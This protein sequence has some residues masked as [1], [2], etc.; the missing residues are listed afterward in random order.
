MWDRSTT[1]AV[2]LAAF[3]LAQQAGT[4]AVA[5]TQTTAAPIF[6]TQAACIPASEGKGYVLYW[7]F[8]ALSHTVITILTVI[9]SWELVQAKHSGYSGGERLSAL[10]VTRYGQLFPI[11]IIAIE[12]FQIIFYLAADEMLRAVSKVV[13]LL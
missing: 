10:L 6:A 1:M 7:I 9:R 8:P 12:V 13:D 11:G 2:V 4:L 5:L 3:G